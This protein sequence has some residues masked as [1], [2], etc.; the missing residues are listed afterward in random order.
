MSTKTIGVL[1]RGCEGKSTTA[2]YLAL[3]L[4]K[5]GRPVTVVSTDN[6]GDAGEAN[7]DTVLAG[8][9]T[10][11]QAIRVT[12]YGYGYVA[13]GEELDV[14]AL[15]LSRSSIG[16]QVLGNH[17]G[18]LDGYV[19]IDG[20]AYNL[21]FWSDSLILASDTILAVTRPL[22]DSAKRLDLMVEHIGMDDPGKYRGFIGTMWSGYR[23]TETLSAMS[24][25]LAR[26]DYLGHVPCRLGRDKRDMVVR[27]NQ[28]AKELFDL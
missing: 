13:G 1:G 18:N 4:V 25:L 28:L 2:H 19:I 7:L 11:E 23:A 22:T 8:K 24:A 5:A 14:Q 15:R 16:A 9:A 6:F 10:I 26:S 3:S 17:L 21:D 27:Y 12:S 20:R